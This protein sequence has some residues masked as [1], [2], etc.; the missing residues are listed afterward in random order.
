MTAK[1]SKN[2]NKQYDNAITKITDG[3]AHSSAIWVLEVKMKQGLVSNAAWVGY[4]DASIGYYDKYWRYSTNQEN[5]YL[6][7]VR[8]AINNGA[9]IENYIEVAECNKNFTTEEVMS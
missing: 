9:V 4:R 2:F 1:T 8:A 6:M 7:G 5:E 3:L